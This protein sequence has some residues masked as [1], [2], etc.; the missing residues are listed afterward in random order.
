[1]GGGVTEKGAGV[2]GWG[3]MGRKREKYTYTKCILEEVSQVISTLKAEP[4][5]FMSLLVVAM[6]DEV[7]RKSLCCI[8]ILEAQLPRI[9][10][11]LDIGRDTARD[12]ARLRTVRRVRQHL[13]LKTDTTT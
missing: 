3:W 12:T 1:M 8:L 9:S 13:V 10:T 7:D 6:G 5:V 2:G 4:D 11:A